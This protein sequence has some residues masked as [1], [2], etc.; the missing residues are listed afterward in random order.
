MTMQYE[1]YIRTYQINELIDENWHKRIISIRFCDNTL[2]K[3]IWNDQDAIED[4]IMDYPNINGQCEEF[5]FKFLIQHSM[6]E[7]SRVMFLFDNL[8]EFYTI[9]TEFG[10]ELCY[11]DKHRITG[12]ATCFDAMLYALENKPWIQNFFLDYPNVTSI[13]K[14]KKKCTIPF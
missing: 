6:N 2:P 9:G 4:F 12:F 10:T 8:Q 5:T 13:K 14:T 1:T 11:Q 7:Y 3:D